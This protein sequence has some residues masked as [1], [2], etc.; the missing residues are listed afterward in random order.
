[1]SEL[2]DLRCGVY[3][4]TE[5]LFCIKDFGGEQLTVHGSVRFL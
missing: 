1:M 2:R 5:E 4:S 3:H